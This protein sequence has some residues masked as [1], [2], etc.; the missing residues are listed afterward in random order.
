MKRRVGLIDQAIRV[1]VAIAA[2]VVSL[3]IGSSTAWG[4]VLLALA[5][6]L[7]LTGLSG[8]CPIY[9]ALGVDTHSEAKKS[10]GHRV[11]H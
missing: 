5:L 9:S 10:S 7:L 8:Y 3:V 4:I 6:L 1:I 2:V 11:A